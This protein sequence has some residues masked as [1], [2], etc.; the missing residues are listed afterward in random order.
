MV[1]YMWSVGGVGGVGVSCLTHKKKYNFAGD[2]RAELPDHPNGR[3]AGTK[4][5]QEE[6]LVWDAQ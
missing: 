5:V 6:C 3:G 4:E 2:P 1:K